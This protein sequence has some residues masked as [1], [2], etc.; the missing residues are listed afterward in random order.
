MPS[1]KGKSR[2]GVSG[3][4]FFI[5]ILKYFGISSSYFFLRFVIIYFVIFSPKASK[6]IYLYFR[7]IHKYSLRKSFVKLFQN[8]YIFGQTLIDKIAILGGFEKKFT[9]SFGSN[10]NDLLKL[11]DANKGCILISAHI[12]NW[13]V[14]GQFFGNYGNRLNIFMLEAEHERIKNLLSGILGDKNYNII[15]LKEDLS[16]IIKINNA[17]SNNEYIC[18]QGDRYVHKDHTLKAKFL[19]KEVLF[20]DGPFKIAAR[21]DVP[22]VFF[23]AMKDT[24]RNYSFNFFVAKSTISEV[25]Q[26]RQ[27]KTLAILNEYVSVF[28]FVVRKYPEQWFNYYNFWE[29]NAS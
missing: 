17:L 26:T 19:G 9:Y 15:G 16:H 11:L 4:K 10:Y 22:V 8:Y 6:A 1:W 23:F 7:Q 3:Y 20:P 27:A 25:G 18:F 12:G 21:Y 28:E 5:F 14:A 24:P 13:E 2:G 29:N